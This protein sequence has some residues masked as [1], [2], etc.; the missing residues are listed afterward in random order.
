[1][2]I[3]WP[4]KIIHIAKAELTLIQ[5]VPTEIRQLDLNAFRLGLRNLEDDNEGMPWPKTHS[6]N[7]TV[8]VGGVILARVVE[9]INDYTVT[10]ED[11]QYAVNLVGAN[12]NVGD[13]VNVN[14]VSV[15]SANSAGL[16][17]LSTLLAS[18]Y[19]NVVCVDV[20]DGQSGTSVPIGTRSTPVNNFAD[21]KTIAEKN[22][23][24]AFQIMQPCTLAGVDLSHGYT[25]IGDNQV[26][27]IL[28]IDPSAVI[29][30]CTFQN[31]SIVGTLDGDNTFTN[32]LLHT[33]NYVNGFLIN[34]AIEDVI[35]LGGNAQCSILDCWSNVAGSGPGQYAII[36][37][38]GSGNS[39]ALR[40]FSGGVEIRNYSGGGEVT[41]DMASGE[42]EIETTVTAGEV[43]VRGIANVID[44]STGTAV[45]IDS[46]V[47]KALD[48][49]LSSGGNLTVD[50][51]AQLAKIYQAHFHKRELVGSNL[52]RIYDVDGTT[53]LHEFSTDVNFTHVTPLP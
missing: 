7:T 15:R 23:I 21:A 17:D 29:D 39:L 4:N 20:L 5:S 2:V 25:F 53:V 52:I 48:Q 31:L 10:F 51:A 42:V 40:N 8:E 14:Q 36:D 26:T 43:V 45:V 22:G 37:M 47:N 11:G 3:D 50:Q 13:V 44:L 6:H 27:V 49:L 41:L 19:N 12:S 16:Q 32:C 1:V 28:T 18:A 34:C 33:I 9:I 35:T 46:T 24:R 38:G 30:Q